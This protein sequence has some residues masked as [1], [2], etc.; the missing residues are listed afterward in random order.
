MTACVVLA[1]VLARPHR[2]EPL[3]HSLHSTTLDARL[4]FLCSP[5]DDDEI[6]ACRV[7]AETVVVPFE[8]GPGD[9]ARKINYGI[10]ITDEEWVFQAADDLDFHPGWLTEAV[11]VATRTSA[12]LIGTQDLGNRLV[13]FGKH[14]THSLVHRSY[15]EEQGTID[16]GGLLHEGYRHNFV[17][18]EMVETA[19]HRREW[20][21][22]KPSVVEHLHPHWRKGEMDDTYELGLSE[23][24][25]D[26]Q[27]FFER[28][29]LWGGRP[30]RPRR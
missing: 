22:A 20:A 29:P 17:D 15:V 4:V 18:T 8:Q 11:R 10:E 19:M 6:A 30:G 23:F 5:G 3:A 16:G 26:Q 14:S 27:R 21:F 2:A 24:K 1:P 13:K 7:V 12:R 28:R 25:V 9:Y